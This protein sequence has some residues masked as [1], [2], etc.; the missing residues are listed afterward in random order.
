MKRHIVLA[1]A[2]AVAVLALTACDPY[3]QGPA[4]TVV[5]KADRYSSATKTRHYF[6]TTTREFEV[7]IS[8]YDSCRRGSAYPH[9]TAAR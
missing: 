2:S 5:G 4:G 7:P 8:V 9:C 6:L 1:A 3:P